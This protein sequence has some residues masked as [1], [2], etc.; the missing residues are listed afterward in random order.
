MTLKAKTL[1]LTLLL[2]ALAL[3]ALAD[4]RGP[5][6]RPGSPGTGALVDGRFLTHY[7][8]LSASQVTQLQGF[9]RTLQTAGQ[10]VQAARVPLCQTLRTD[11]NASHPD[12]L[13]VGR[14]FL[15]LV[16][17]QDRVKTALQSFDTSFS[18]ILNGDQLARYDAL[19]Q[20]VER[21]TGKSP[22]PLPTCP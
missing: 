9:L 1:S 10:A 22:D 3:P 12:P 7:L 18:A 20:I 4:V 17:N 21:G 16:D 19:K 15:A 6:G 2:G 8:N 11:L 13:T 5:S 14:D